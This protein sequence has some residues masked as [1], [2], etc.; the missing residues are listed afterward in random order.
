MQ[1]PAAARGS[2]TYAKDDPRLIGSSRSAPRERHRLPQMPEAAPLTARR[3]SGR[4]RGGQGSCVASRS[5]PLVVVPRPERR[6]RAIEPGPL[7]CA[8]ALHLSLPCESFPTSSFGGQRLWWP[9]GLPSPQADG[10]SPRRSLTPREALWSPS[11]KALEYV[12]EALTQPACINPD[13][14]PNGPDQQCSRTQS[15]RRRRVR[16]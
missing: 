10:T 15:S 6:L 5:V 16:G 13:R 14:A 11:A 8:C 12:A 1:R 9:T 7:A 4:R 2:W 3:R